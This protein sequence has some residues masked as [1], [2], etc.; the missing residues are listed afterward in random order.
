MTEHY[1]QYASLA[2]NLQ[3]PLTEHDLVTALTSHFPTEIQRAMLA[4]NLRSSQEALAFLGRMQSLENSQ[5]VYKR[6][7]Q[8]QNSKDFDRKQPKGR[9]QGGGSSYRDT[10]RDVRH[11]RYGY[12]RSDSGTPYRQNTPVRRCNYQ[13]DR[14]NMRQARKLNSRIPEFQPRHIDERQRSEQVSMHTER[15]TVNNPNQEN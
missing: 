7:K 12:R 10:P 5:E 4:S 2:A 13:A 9:D 15:P 6:A 8:E 1:A 3:P 11:V 14:R